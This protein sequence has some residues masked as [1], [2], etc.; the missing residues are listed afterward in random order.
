ML[1]DARNNKRPMGLIGHLSNCS[2]AFA[3]YIHVHYNYRANEIIFVSL[4]CRGFIPGLF[5]SINFVQDF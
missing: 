2:V 5:N 1:L 3:K 4:W